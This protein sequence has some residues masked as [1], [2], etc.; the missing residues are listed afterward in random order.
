MIIIVGF[1]H[2]YK[3]IDSLMLNNEK[4]GKTQSA[5]PTF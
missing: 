5:Y 3:E 2:Y 1:S 4:S